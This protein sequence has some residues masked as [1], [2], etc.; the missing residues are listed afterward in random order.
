V[1]NDERFQAVD[2]RPQGTHLR[3]EHRLD[4]WQLVLVLVVISAM[5]VILASAIANIGNNLAD[6]HIIQREAVPLTPAH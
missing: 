2:I 1:V 4:W 6:P 3:H 5:L